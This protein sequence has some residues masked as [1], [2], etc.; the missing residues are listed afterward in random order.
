[1]LD[2]LRRRSLDRKP[3]LKRLDPPAR[4]PRRRVR[5]KVLSIACP[6]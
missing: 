6:A 1:M 4:P 2:V 5:A 3:W